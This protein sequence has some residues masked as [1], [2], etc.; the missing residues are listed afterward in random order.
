M[1]GRQAREFA[2]CGVDA[3]ADMPIQFVVFQVLVDV[4]QVH[5]L[6]AVGA[7]PG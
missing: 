5:L 6:G 4:A 7:V 1:A 3:P 2:R